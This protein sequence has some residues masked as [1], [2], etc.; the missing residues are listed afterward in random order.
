ME[1]GLGGL[2]FV[3]Q[4]FQTQPITHEDAPALAVISKMLRSCSCTEIREKGG[5]YGGLPSIEMDNGR[6]YCFCFLPGPAHCQH[7]N[8]YDA[9]STFIVSSNYTEEDIKEA[10]LQ[11]CADVVIRTPRTRPRE[12]PFTGNLPA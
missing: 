6:D 5:A 7:L 2:S 12:K 3:A 10:I 9:A 4:T 1:H 8:V 11:V